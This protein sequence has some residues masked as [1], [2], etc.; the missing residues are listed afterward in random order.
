M[1]RKAKK[2][3]RLNLMRIQRNMS[4]EELAQKSGVSLRMLQLYEIGARDISTAYFETV[5]RLAEVLDCLC[6]DIVGIIDK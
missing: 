2:I 4:R 1:A 3:T 5:Q 6:E